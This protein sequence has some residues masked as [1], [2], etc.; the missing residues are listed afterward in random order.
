MLPEIICLGIMFLSVTTVGTVAN[1]FLFTSYLLNIIAGHKISCL[2]LIF[3]QLTLVNSITLI[4]KGVPQTL[5]GLGWRNFLDDVGCKVV[6]YLRKVSEGL[7][8]SLTCLL[9]T[10]QAITINLGNSRWAELK[11]RFTQHITPAFLF[12]WILNLLIE[13][14]IPVSARGPKSRSNNVTHAFDNVFCTSEYIM[15]V[16]LIITTFRNVFCL[17]LMVSASGYMVL[18]LH[19]HH[20]H[21]QK[22]RSTKHS[23]RRHP[24]IRATQTILLL[25][26]TFVSF[27]ALT[28]IFTLFL[29]Y[30][31]RKSFWMLPT[32]IFLSLCYPTI[33]PFLLIPRCC[34]PTYNFL[35]K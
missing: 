24:E 13:I 19:K 17:G 2:T 30:F 12:C 35:A 34:R 8:I 3:T 33:S 26:S 22:I 16:Y 5:Q 10:F 7:S 23:Q 18:L 1:F 9:C 21:V 29:S 20:Q 4:S 27:Y 14:P 11:V 28:S 32:A 31:D 15:G 25:M 6:F